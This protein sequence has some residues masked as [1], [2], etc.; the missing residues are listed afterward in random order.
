[1]A[2]LIRIP[3]RLRST[4]AFRP[5]FFT[6]SMCLLAA[7][8]ALLANVEYSTSPSL[9]LKGFLHIIISR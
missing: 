9:G 3:K 5:F 1:M 6:P 2:P 7:M 8:S 4:D